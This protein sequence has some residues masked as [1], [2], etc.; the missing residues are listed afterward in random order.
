M[1]SGNA[2][3]TGVSPYQ[4]PTSAANVRTL[5]PPTGNTATSPLITSDGT[6][7][8]IDGHGYI[9]ALENSGA[10]SEKWTYT[11]PSGASYGPAAISS[12]GGKLY[13]ASDKLY[14]IDIT[15]NPP[16][17]AWSLALA[18]YVYG[19]VIIGSDGVIYFNTAG[20]DTSVG[21]TAVF[22]NGT[23]YWTAPA[24]GSCEYCSPAVAKDGSAIYSGSDENSY[25][26]AFFPDGTLSWQAATSYYAH[27]V[28]VS[29]DGT[30]IAG[31]EDFKVYQFSPDGTQKWVWTAT[32]DFQYSQ[33]SIGTDG[34]VY[35]G[36][37]DSN[38][39]AINANGTLRWS[40]TTGNEITAP[41]VIAADGSIYFAAYDSIVYAL[42]A[43][44]TQKWSYSVGSAEQFVGG[45]VISASGH[46]YVLLDD[47]RLFEF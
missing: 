10:G 11:L 23:L 29:P 34:T 30:I 28:A 36:C 37:D 2:Q 19:A 4:G 20:S 18:G 5:L 44:G 45:P 7:Y 40:Y 3:L 35:I 41:P 24:A 39:Y 33:P 8:I 26:Y 38:M 31:T 14:A 27:G 42:N 17:L 1:L 16:T 25:V 6:M 22:P 13:Y 32:S 12:D 9:H 43:D 46:L 47:G 21:L 15:T